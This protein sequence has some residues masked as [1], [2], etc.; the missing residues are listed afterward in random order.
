MNKDSTHNKNLIVCVVEFI[1]CL[2][3]TKQDELENHLNLLI[4]KRL[5]WNYKYKC[6]RQFN[7]AYIEILKNK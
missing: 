5:I 7:I 1:K 6:Y 2:S 3:Y 4:V